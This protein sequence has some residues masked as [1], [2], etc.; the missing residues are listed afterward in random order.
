MTHDYRTPE[1]GQRRLE[2]R[3]RAFGPQG[4]VEELG[5]GWVLR[6]PSGDGWRSVLEEFQGH[7]QE[8][9]SWV[10]IHVEAR[11]GERT[12]LTLCGSDAVKR[13]GQQEM[14]LARWTGSP[15]RAKAER[16]WR[17]TTSFARTLPDF[18]IAG[19]P[20]SGTWTMFNALGRHPSIEMSAVK[21]VAWF[22]VR[23][24]KSALWYRRSFPTMFQRFMTR[25]RTGAFATGEATPTYLFHPHAARRIKKLI[26]DVK[27][28][29][30]LRNPVQRAYSHYHWAVR[31]GFEPLSF[32]DVIDRE[33]GRVAGELEKMLADE[34]Y[35]SFPRSYL[36]YI[37]MGRYAEQIE[38]WLEVFP[39]EQFLFLSTD[40]LKRDTGDVLDR[41]ARFLGL[42]TTA[43]PESKRANKGF[44]PKASA[45]ARERL[46]DY[47]R[48][49]NE[50]LWELLGTDYGWNKADP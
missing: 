21:E 10:G 44:Y 33:E 50:R 3:R 12:M 35:L 16:M 11:A 45:S 43:L 1:E 26:P 22:N 37:G 17:A 38:D 27:L 31:M 7:V 24:D 19:A 34:N 4:D 49:H 6:F 25:R 47:F 36:S 23:Y 30:M 15:R 9:Y 20:R 28:I 48:P 8:D 2:L 39:R 5:D 13:W 40:E 32:D 14:D 29:I 41:T 42:H 18:L 46:S